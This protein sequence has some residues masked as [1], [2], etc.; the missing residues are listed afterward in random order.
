MILTAVI[1]EDGLSLWILAF[2]D[3]N[4]SALN[5]KM[6]GAP[7]G[8]ASTEV[9]LIFRRRHYRY[10]WRVVG[11]AGTDRQREWF[12]VATGGWRVQPCH[13]YRKSVA[14]TPR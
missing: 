8:M 11:A 12:E 5:V 6:S 14:S 3:V 7:T 9:E 4:A 10:M 1:S 13:S 2:L